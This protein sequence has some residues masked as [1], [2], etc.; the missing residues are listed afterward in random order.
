MSERHGGRGKEE[1]LDKRKIR[2]RVREEEE[3]KLGKR[4]WEKD[5]GRVRGRGKGGRDTAS[6]Y[7]VYSLQNNKNDLDR[8]ATFVLIPKTQ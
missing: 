2:E 7:L 3:W 1:R 8:N 5:R 4:K 6:P